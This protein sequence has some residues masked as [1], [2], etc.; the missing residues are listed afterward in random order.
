MASVRSPATPEKKSQGHH[1]FAFYHAAPSRHQKSPG[2]L[3]PNVLSSCSAMARSLMAVAVAVTLG[4]VAVATAS[5][6]GDAVDTAAFPHDAADGGQPSA[7]FDA[8]NC[9]RDWIG[10][11]HIHSVGGHDAQGVV[12]GAF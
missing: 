8:G 6:N 7:A 5:V 1:A 10:D 11:L 3:W 4:T 9:F 12:R 2:D